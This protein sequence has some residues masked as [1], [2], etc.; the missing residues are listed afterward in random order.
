LYDICSICLRAGQV[1]IRSI[2]LSGTSLHVT[3][4]IAT[5][6]LR[7]FVYNFYPFRARSGSPHCWPASSPSPA[8][9]STLEGE[10]NPLNHPYVSNLFVEK[11]VTAGM[12]G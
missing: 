9:S 5:R 8:C 10:I 2:T 12:G 6:I 4:A 3:A 7:P 1:C 11:D